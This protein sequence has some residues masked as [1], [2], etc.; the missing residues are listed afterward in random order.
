MAGFEVTLHGRIGVTP[1]GQGAARNSLQEIALIAGEACSMF[2][3]DS[4]FQLLGLP[5]RVRHGLYWVYDVHAN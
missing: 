5:G 4:E 3:L 2:I 1:E